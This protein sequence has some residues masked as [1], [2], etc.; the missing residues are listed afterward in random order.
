MQNSEAYDI[1]YTH[2][3]SFGGKI[4]RP[5]FDQLMPVLIYYMQIANDGKDAPDIM[6][7][8]ATLRHVSVRQVAY[9]LWGRCVQKVGY[10][11][12]DGDLMVYA[13]SAAK[14]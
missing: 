8:E 10:R 5:I 11:K 1:V 14:T 12:Y 13:L 7:I 6:Q 3:V 9:E 2:Y 4:E